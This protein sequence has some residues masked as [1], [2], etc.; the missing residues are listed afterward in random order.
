MQETVAVDIY[1]VDVIELL[2]LQLQPLLLLPEEDVA[3]VVVDIYDVGGVLEVAAREKE[4]AVD[5]C[6][7]DVMQ[8]MVEVLV[9]LE[10]DIS[11]VGEMEMVVLDVVLGAVALGGIY[12]LDVLVLEEVGMV[13][14]LDI[15]KVDVM[16][17]MAVMNICNVAV[18]VMK[19]VVP[20]VVLV[21]DVDVEE[22]EELLVVVLMKALAGLEDNSNLVGRHS[23]W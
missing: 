6:N 14:V 1:D 13:A 10:K 2:L 5:V 23:F 20:A 7:A 22:Q 15:Y 4:L 8:E 11:D 16:G 18:V 12:K 17:L 21:D 9:L 3:V 19:A